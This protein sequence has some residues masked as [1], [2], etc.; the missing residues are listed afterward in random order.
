VIFE[1]PLAMPALRPVSERTTSGNFGVVSRS[2]SATHL[3]AD[4][5]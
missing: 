4:A 5:R 2:L 1:H 3:S